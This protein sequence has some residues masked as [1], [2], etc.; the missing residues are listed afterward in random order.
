MHSC[1][2][3]ITRPCVTND[4][5]AT[6][7]LVSVVGNSGMVQLGIS[8]LQC[9]MKLWSDGPCGGSPPKLPHSHIGV[10]AGGPLTA[11]VPQA[12]VVSPYGVSSMAKL[13]YLPWGDTDR[14][15]SGICVAFHGLAP[16]VTTTTDATFNF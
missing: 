2:V 9:F 13:R 5:K 12:L 6:L 15:G 3:F 7:T 8:G 11:G 14:Q 16:E 1:L 4:G 10:W